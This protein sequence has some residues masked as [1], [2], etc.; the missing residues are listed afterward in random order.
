MNFFGP[1]AKCRTANSTEQADFNRLAEQMEMNEN[2]FTATQ[3]N[4]PHWNSITS[5]WDIPASPYPL[6]TGRRLL[7][8][9]SWAPAGF[10][11]YLN[12]WISNDP[13][14]GIYGT[15]PNSSFFWDNLV[16]RDPEIRN[17]LVQTSNSSIVCSLINASFEVTIASVN[18][19]QQIT[20]RGIT[21][22]PTDVHVFNNTAT[23]MYTSQFLALGAT[24][25]GNATLTIAG[26]L[27]G[28]DG[29]KYWWGTDVCGNIALG[30]LG[31]EEIQQSPFMPKLRTAALP[32][33]LNS[34]CLTQNYPC[35]NRSI[36]R[37]IEDLSN[38]ITISY[39]SS[40][41]LT[42]NEVRNITTSNTKIVYVYRPL[43]LIL[44]YGVGFLFTFIAA[45]VGLYSIHLNGVSYSSLFSTFLA[46]TRNS[47][48]DALT[49][50]A[51]L[52]AD[53]SIG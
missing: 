9:Y 17:I 15:S 10:I 44:S 18:G 36:L 32:D 43:F 30:L 23:N 7:F 40:P 19:E 38:N 3:M 21:P 4:D 20:Q 52:G 45:V 29:W 5:P 22:T 34:A 33:E 35:R 46:T 12:Y 39:L 51:S 28:D 13:N 14:S 1:S 25:V 8:Y 6:G 37:A 53:P 47:D 48:L 31:C 27:P 16:G 24:L 49:S 2:I 50:G 26:S 42:S 41:N 11:G